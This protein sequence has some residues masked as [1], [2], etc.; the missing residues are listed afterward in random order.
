MCQLANGPQLPGDQILGL[1]DGRKYLEYVCILKVSRIM[2]GHI[3][4]VAMSVFQNILAF[5]VLSNI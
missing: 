1:P 5:Y 2:V 4:I 3:R